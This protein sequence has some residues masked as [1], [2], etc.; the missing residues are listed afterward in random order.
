MELT[1]LQ[2]YDQTP[3]LELNGCLYNKILDT[4]SSNFDRVY[5]IEDWETGDRYGDGDGDWGNDDIK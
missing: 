2:L 1:Q 3:E 4:V 5:D